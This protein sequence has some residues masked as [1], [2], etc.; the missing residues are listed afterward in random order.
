MK[1]KNITNE[2]FSYCMT[3]KRKIAKKVFNKLDYDVAMFYQYYDDIL[4]EK[5]SIYTTI[6]DYLFNFIKNNTSD[7]LAYVKSLEA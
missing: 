6:P 5:N 1:P 4:I 3:D 2:I 7:I